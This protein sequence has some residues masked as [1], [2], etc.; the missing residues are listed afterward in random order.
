[1]S[2][3]FT[4]SYDKKLNYLIYTLFMFFIFSLIFCSFY[5]LY[6]ISKIEEVT[7][8]YKSAQDGYRVIYRVTDNENVLVQYCKYEGDI[9]N[10]I[11]KQT[12][13]VTLNKNVICPDDNLLYFSILF[14]L[15]SLLFTYIPIALCVYYDARQF[16]KNYEK[17]DENKKDKKN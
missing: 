2:R 16:W 7:A 11:K 17:E 1:M 9:I 5:Y 12:V 13:L 6:F 14:L 4:W 15:G 10:Y 8:I 3:I